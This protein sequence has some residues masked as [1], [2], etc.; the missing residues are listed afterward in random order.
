ML[1]TSVWVGVDPRLWELATRLACRKPGD[2]LPLLSVR[3]AVTSQVAEYHTQNFIHHKISQK[4][5]S[6]R[7]MRPF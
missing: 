7:Q 1:D 3:P 4:L 5:N 2:R 6:R